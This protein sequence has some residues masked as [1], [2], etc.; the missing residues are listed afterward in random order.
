[1]LL[2]W[3]KLENASYLTFG[4][5][6]AIALVVSLLNGCAP[7]EYRKQQFSTQAS[8]AG[9]RFIPAK[10][11]I[12]FVPDNSASLNIA[13]STVQ[14]QLANFT[15][16]LKSMYWDYHVARSLMINPSAITQVLV[17]PQFNVDHLPDGT[18]IPTTGLS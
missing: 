7:P 16:E 17:N 5:I 12:V 1:M 15:N 14:S 3:K 4:L 6:A 18:A 2:K 8:S 10:I 11:D 9:S 13:M